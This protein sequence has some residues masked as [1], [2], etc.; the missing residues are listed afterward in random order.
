MSEK[1]TAKCII[2]ENGEINI[3][4]DFNRSN[5]ITL[6]RHELIYQKELEKKTIK[7]T[8]KKDGT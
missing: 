8:I 2:K 7:E 5:L 6:L 4:G 3:E 1:E